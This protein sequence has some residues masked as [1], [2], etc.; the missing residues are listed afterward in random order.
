MGTARVVVPI[1]ILG[2]SLLFVGC[3][4]DDRSDTLDAL[5]EME[6][7]EGYRG[8][9]VSDA[10]IQELEEAIDRYQAIVEEKVD[11]A[12]QLGVYYKMLGQE[13]LDQG[14]YRLALDAFDSALTIHPENAVLYYRAGL[15]AAQYAGSRVDPVEHE[16]LIRRAQTYYE[17][18]LT[19]EPTNPDLLYALSVLNVFELEAPDEAIPLLEDLRDR[20]PGNVSALF[21]LGRAYAEAGRVNQAVEAYEAAAE[22]ATSEDVRSRALQ[23]AAEL[24]GPGGVQ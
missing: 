15:A 14:V 3:E 10:R 13:Y 8:A 21:L 7:T 16:E 20:E 22:S 23:N 9:E 24:L 2:L 6:S 18:G 11:A 19:I 4:R 5:L 1:W 12:N 17:R